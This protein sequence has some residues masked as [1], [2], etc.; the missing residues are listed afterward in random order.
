M[1]SHAG[2]YDEKGDPDNFLHIFEGAIR[3][4][5]WLMH[6]ACHMFTYTLKDS[7][8]IWWNSQKAG[9]IL[10]YEDLKA[11]FRSHFGLQKRFTKTHLAVHIIK[12][13]EGGSVRA[14]ATRIKK[15][16]AKTSNSQRGEKKEKSTTPT[17]AHILMINQEEARARNSISENLNFKG[18]E[19]MFPPVTKGNNSSAP[20]VIKANIFEREVGRVYMDSGSSCGVIY[21]HFFLKLNPFIQASKLDSYVLLVGFF[22][23]KSWAIR[24]VLLEVTIG[25]APLS[26]SE[27][28]KFIIVRSNSL[29]KMLLGRTTMQKIGMVVSMIHGAVKFHTT[30]GIEI[31]FSTHE[32]DKIDG[33]KKIRE[34]SPANTKRGSQLH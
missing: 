16:R 33:V 31:V 20:V 7:A 13:R 24:E 5:K 21:E 9:S 34:T 3:M 32:S 30:K 25:D 10:N 12:Q 17:E 18:R 29:Y 11:K 19:I 23:R 27:T 2:S 26:R 22:R 4:Q 1:P 6:V 8:R 28:L 14:F 15:E